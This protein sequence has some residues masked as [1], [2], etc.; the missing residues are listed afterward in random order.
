MLK[1]KIIAE[2]YT[3]WYNFLRSVGRKV[4]LFFI[5]FTMYVNSNP[6]HCAMYSMQHYVIKFVISITVTVRSVVLCVGTMGSCPGVPRAKEPHTNLCMMYTA[7][8]LMFKHW[9]CWKYQYKKYMFNCI[10]HVKNTVLFL[11]VFV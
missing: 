6:A 11:R 4:G 2:G 1:L 5:F 7:W 9:F 10:D 8:F 3:I